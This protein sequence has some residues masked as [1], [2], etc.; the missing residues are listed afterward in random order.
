M[1]KRAAMLGLWAFFASAF[2]AAAARAGEPA[3]SSLYVIRYDRWSDA[4]ERGYREFVQAI[5]ESDCDTLD[6]CLRSDANPFRGT[7]APGR[8]FVSDCAE[9]PYILRFYYA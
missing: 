2:L 4:D 5:G 8:K 3:P 9:L 1:L 6:T 7:D